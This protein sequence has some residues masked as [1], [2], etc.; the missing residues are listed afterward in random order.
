MPLVNFFLI[1]FFNRRKHQKA[2][3]WFG[4]ER[5]TSEFGKNFTQLENCASP[6]TSPHSQDSFFLQAFQYH[7]RCGPSR[8]KIN[9]E[10]DKNARCVCSSAPNSGIIPLVSSG[11]LFG[12][13]R[14]VSPAEAAREV[15]SSNCVVVGSEKREKEKKKIEKKSHFSL[16][17]FELAHFLQGCCCPRSQVPM[18]PWIVGPLLTYGIYYLFL[19]LRTRLLG[20]LHNISLRE[21]SGG[22]PPVPESPQA[23]AREKDSTGDIMCTQPSMSRCM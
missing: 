13:L 6:D 4:G 10:E 12:Y 22:P 19:S 16:T 5:P 11:R 14:R 3:W 8:V 2:N 18:P 21:P 23:Q 7:P 20:L 17:L 15:V 9:K 1:L